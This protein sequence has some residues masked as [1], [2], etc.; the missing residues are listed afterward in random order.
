MHK[1]RH[2]YIFHK[3][4]QLII[5]WH[6]HHCLY[7]ALVAITP[8]SNL[9]LQIA[10]SLTLELSDIF[11]RQLVPETFGEMTRY[12][13]NLPRTSLD[14][15]LQVDLPLVN[16]PPIPKQVR[17]RPPPMQA[18]HFHDTRVRSKPPPVHAT[19]LRNR[20]K[21]QSENFNANNRLIVMWCNDKSVIILCSSFSH[22]SRR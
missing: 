7:S 20:R 1:I 19:Q 4:V 12:Q 18:I 16:G 22:M 17:S 9:L 6:L 8:S 21:H 3:A 11:C 14:L 2:K 13:M 10:I 5:I 15:Q